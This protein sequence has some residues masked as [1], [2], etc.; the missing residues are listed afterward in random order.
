M[1]AEAAAPKSKTKYTAAKTRREELVRQAR[2]AEKMKEK[3]KEKPASSTE[4][5]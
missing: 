3:E 2:E 5:A 1:V 4:A